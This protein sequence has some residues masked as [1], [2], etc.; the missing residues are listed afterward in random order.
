VLLP[1][2]DLASMRDHIWGKET[3]IDFD[4]AINKAVNRLR[5]LLGDDVAH[6]R[7]IE[8]LPKHGYRF[9]ADV[10]DSSS[11]QPSAADAR[12][13]FLKARYFWNKR[14]PIDLQRS[15][16]Y[17]RRTIERP[18][19]FALA[20]TGLADAYVMIGIFGLQQPREVFVPAKTAAQRALALDG[21]LAEAHAVLADI[22]KCYDWNWVG[23]EQ[24]CR[25]PLSSIRLRRGTPMVRGVAR[26]PRTAR[27]S[28]D[29]N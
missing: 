16:E 26:H 24:S 13:N 11:R 9:V 2:A 23:A 29:G 21:A 1:I 17:F 15:I 22:Q 7:F 10:V 27:R 3:Y 6:P 19:D 18:P 14:T 25:R 20:W 12:E 5:Q 28:M 8:T 4:R